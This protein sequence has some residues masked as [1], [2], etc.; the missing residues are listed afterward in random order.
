VSVAVQ[1]QEVL[2]RR[3]QLDD[4]FDGTK[5]ANG[6]PIPIIQEIKGDI[7][8]EISIAIEQL[9]PTFKLFNNWLPELGG[10]QYH[11]LNVFE[12]VV[13]NESQANIKAADI[14]EEICTVMHF[15]PSGLTAE[16]G[17]PSRFQMMEVPFEFLSIGPPVHYVVNLQLNVLL[18]T[19]IQ[20]SA[21]Y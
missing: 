16:R 9:V 4:L 13:I 8:N 6:Q 7:A 18:P 20:P 11:K 10:W 21:P 19:I 2:V 12:H 15:Y 3:L 17:E 14:C 1:A 5:S